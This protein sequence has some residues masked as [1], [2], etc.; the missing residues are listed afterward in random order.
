[1]PYGPL[2]ITEAGP[3]QPTSSLLALSA[4]RLRRPHVGGPCTSLR[5]LSKRLVGTLRRV[6]PFRPISTARHSR[7]AGYRPNFLQVIPPSTRNAALSALLVRTR[8]GLEGGRSKACSDNRPAGPGPRASH[9]P[10]VWFKS[11]LSSGDGLES[12]GR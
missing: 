5:L 10:G 2:P 12:C 7:F 6:W 3:P 9:H 8:L 1:M 11:E 4:Q